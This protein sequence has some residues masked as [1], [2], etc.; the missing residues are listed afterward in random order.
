[1]TRL[2]EKKNNRSPEEQ[3]YFEMSTI[4]MTFLHLDDSAILLIVNTL[5][6]ENIV[7]LRGLLEYVNKLDSNTRLELAERL[8]VLIRDY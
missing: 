5:I 6:D 8:P 2:L 4:A 3:E 7:T 1:M